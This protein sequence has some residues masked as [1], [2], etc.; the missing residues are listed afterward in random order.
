MINFKGSLPNAFLA[1]ALFSGLKHTQNSKKV[2]DCLFILSR[3]NEQHSQHSWRVQSLSPCCLTEGPLCG[4]LKWKP[5]RAWL[6]LLIV[7]A[8]FCGRSCFSHCHFLRFFSLFFLNLLML[9]QRHH[10][11]IQ[12]YLLLLAWLLQNLQILLLVL[13]IYWYAQAWGPW[14]FVQHLLGRCQ[15]LFPRQNLLGVPDLHVSS[16]WPGFLAFLHF[17]HFSLFVPF[18]CVCVIFNFIFKLSR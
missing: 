13:Q 7:T 18:L 11:P 15:G 4:C 17:Q 5:Y 12:L 16:V 1:N 6:V 3:S 14:F 8:I 10:L 2:W 9:Y